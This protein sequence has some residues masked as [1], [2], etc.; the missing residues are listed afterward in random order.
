MDVVDT[1]PPLRGHGQ[2]YD[3]RPLS[4]DPSFPHSD[5][6]PQGVSWT[7][8]VEVMTCQ[9]GLF[10]PHCTVLKHASKRVLIESDAS[11]FEK[12]FFKV[13]CP[14]NGRLSVFSI[15]SFVHIRVVRQRLAEVWLLVQS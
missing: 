15:N 11:R 8:Y 10:F 9:I 2:V 3:E 5:I 13:D 1:T 6:S 12:P 4:S 7:I 14:N